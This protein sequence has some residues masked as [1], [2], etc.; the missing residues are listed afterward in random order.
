MD[1]RLGYDIMLTPDLADPPEVGRPPT[2]PG[3]RSVL[4]QPERNRSIRDDSGR[5][6]ELAARG[7]FLQLTLGSL[8]GIHVPK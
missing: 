2:V 8:T 6:A 5:A 3:F 7:V 4:A 1:P